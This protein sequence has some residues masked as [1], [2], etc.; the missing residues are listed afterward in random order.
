MVNRFLSTKLIG[1]YRFKQDSNET[2]AI[3]EQKGR[4]T[5]LVECFSATIHHSQFLLPHWS[6]YMEMPSV[7]TGK[8]LLLPSLPPGKL[9]VAQDPDFQL[10][11]SQNWE[12]GNSTSR[13][14][15]RCKGARKQRY[16]RGPP[17]SSGNLW[18]LVCHSLCPLLCF[19]LS[20]SNQSTSTSP[21]RPVLMSP[22]PRLLL[23]I[24]DIILSVDMLTRIFF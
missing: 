17:N 6:K 21:N 13:A 18:A 3:S 23:A 15:W 8:M 2:H 10:N 9:L 4:T 7:A 22:P 24:N 20:C 12:V 1:I 5:F 14:Q 16:Q 19:L 11:Q